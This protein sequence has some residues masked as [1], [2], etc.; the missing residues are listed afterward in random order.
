MTGKN[1]DSSEINMVDFFTIFWQ[2]RRLF[3]IC[4]IVLALLSIAYTVFVPIKKKYIFTQQ[5]TL[6][7]YLS[8]ESTFYHVIPSAENTLNALNN[9]IIPNLY[10][11]LTSKSSPSNLISENQPNNLTFI[12]AILPTGNQMQ[13]YIFIKWETTADN[14]P[15]FEK[16]I[17]QAVK[18]LQTQEQLALQTVKSRIT[19]AIQSLQNKADFFNHQIK[20]L[21]EQ[22]DAISNQI[23]T[24]GKTFNSTKTESDNLGNYFMFTDLISSRNQL[25]QQLMVTQQAKINLNLAENIANLKQQLNSL[26]LTTVSKNVAITTL[27]GSYL[28]NKTYRLILL[29]ILSVIISLLVVFTVNIVASKPN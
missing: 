23:N 4:F 21:Q 14:L 11:Q 26:T 13:K 28:Q 25:R 17:A 29:L 27:S 5:V 18:T 15:I 10:Q 7:H 3:S 22:L 1:Q 16:V 24:S 9:S 8:D 19:N 12:N 6:A 2:K 20:S